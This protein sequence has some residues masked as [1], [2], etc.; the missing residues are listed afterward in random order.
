MENY[1]IL[2]VDDETAYEAI[3]SALLVPLGCR[4]DAVATPD[5]ACDAVKRERYDLV[6]MDIDLGEGEDGFAT[7]ERLRAMTEWLSECPIIAFTKLKPA[8]DEA[9]FQERGLDGWLSK[10]FT[11]FDFITT[12]R[13]WIAL[14]PPVPTENKLAALLGAEAAGQMVDRLFVSLGEAVDAIDAGADPARTGHR[15][16]GLAGTMGYSVLSASWLSLQDGDFS[17]WPTVRALTTEA[18]AKHGSRAHA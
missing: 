16:G 7:A 3:V 17:S 15:L 18:I 14:E 8:G 5:A 4:I 2:L 9:Y 11:A 1:G 6:L 12:V 10:P 13:R